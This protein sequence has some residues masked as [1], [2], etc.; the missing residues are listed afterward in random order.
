[1]FIFPILQQLDSI[2]HKFEF[3]VD[4]FFFHFQPFNCCNGWR[5]ERQVNSEVFGLVKYKII[6][7]IIIKSD[8]WAW[9]QF[10]GLFWNTFHYHCTYLISWKFYLISFIMQAPKFTLISSL[11]Y[12]LAVF[13]FFNLNY[14]V[15]GVYF[16]LIKK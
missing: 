3:K 2:S 6:K 14:R 9:Y 13:F 12:S 4:Q 11:I 5:K 1:M 16:R 15:L 8:S 10:K 7:T